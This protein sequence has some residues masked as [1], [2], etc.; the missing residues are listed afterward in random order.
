VTSGD[1]IDWAR[2]RERY[3][4]T[5]PLQLLDE[6]RDARIAGDLLL[7]SWA[8]TSVKRS[9]DALLDLEGT[10]RLAPHDVMVR[11]ELEC[12]RAQVR[13]GKKE[14][15]DVANRWWDSAQSTPDPQRTRRIAALTAA[16]GTRHGSVEHEFANRRLVQAASQQFEEEPDNP[17]A[18]AS[19]ATGYWEL[20][21]REAAAGALEV[22]RRS[23][24]PPWPGLWDL[25]SAIA[26]KEVDWARA[27]SSRLKARELRGQRTPEWLYFA[28]R[29]GSL[30]WL[31]LWLIGCAFAIFGLVLPTLI[32][33]VI[34][35]ATE[36]V[37]ADV[38]QVPARRAI[39]SRRDNDARAHG[40]AD[41]RSDRRG[42]RGLAGVES[43]AGTSTRRP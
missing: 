7:R 20:R 8:L 6:L 29:W 41:P 26:T 10:A 40:P 30:L 3:L 16:L 23:G 42:R 15:I 27:W 1:A 19:L 2:V 18:V 33:A 38:N 12:V 11:V 22:L 37:V 4:N 25:D 31:L 24:F 39:T 5:P 28:F 32:A 17:T 13:G 36:L 9:A 35:V 21:D 43:N 14:K 34:I